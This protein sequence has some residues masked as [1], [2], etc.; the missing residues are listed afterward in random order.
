MSASRASSA[1]LQ[2]TPSV[3]AFLEASLS[4]PQTQAILDSLLVGRRKRMHR[5][6]EHA[7]REGRK[8]GA[9]EPGGEVR[10]MPKQVWGE[11]RRLDARLGLQLTLW[12]RDSW[13]YR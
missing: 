3:A 1:G 7:H 8:R 2:A 13:T 5:S 4:H 9:A 11:V 6:E 10:S 12:C